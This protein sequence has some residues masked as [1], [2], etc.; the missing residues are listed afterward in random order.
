[1]AEA[2]QK[3]VD[4]R[5]LEVAVEAKTKADG[6]AGNI[7]RLDRHVSDMRVENTTQHQSAQNKISDGLGSVHKRIDRILWAFICGMGCI[8]MMLAAVWLQ[9]KQGVLP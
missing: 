6:V 3:V 2:A 4:L 9:I 8:I 5:A 1:M 7:E